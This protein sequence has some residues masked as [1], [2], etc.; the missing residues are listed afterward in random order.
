SLAPV[1]AAL[2]ASARC[3]AISGSAAS[4]ASV[5]V[6]DLAPGAVVS[7]ARSSPTAMGTR[8]DDGTSTESTPTLPTVSCAPAVHGAI[9]ND[10]SR[11]IRRT[12]DRIPSSHVF[13]RRLARP[14]D[15]DL[16]ARW[17]AHFDRVPEV[18]D[19]GEG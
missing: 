14:A 11:M 9:H 17:T 4:A 2:I 7:I 8:S 18:R 5:A 19:H 10:E 16:P 13:F 12:R 6:R 15:E 1:S 3:P